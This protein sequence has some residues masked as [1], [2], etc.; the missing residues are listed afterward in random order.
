MESAVLTTLA[1]YATIMV[2][3]IVLCTTIVGAIAFW[4][5]EKEQAQTFSFLLQRANALQMLT[6]ILIIV[7][8]VVLRAT[9]GINAEA[10]VSILSGIAGYVLGGI[11]W[12]QKEEKGEKS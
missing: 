4:K 3:S 10:V 7:A 11:K 9:N 6:V 12:N 1:F 2:V 8:A 5:S